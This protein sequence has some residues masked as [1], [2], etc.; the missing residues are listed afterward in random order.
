[1]LLHILPGAE[2]HSTGFKSDERS[3]RQSC[4][5]LTRLSGWLATS[6]LGGER[7]RRGLGPGSV[8]VAVWWFLRRFVV[9]QRSVRLRS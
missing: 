9:T 1:M 2:R 7:R 4:L 8:V 5:L 6:F 3:E